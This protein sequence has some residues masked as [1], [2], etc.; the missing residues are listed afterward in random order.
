MY[1]IRM[2]FFSSRERQGA[3]A[4]PINRCYPN[5]HSILVPAV[6]HKNIVVRKTSL[7]VCEQSRWVEFARDM[8]VFPYRGRFA[9]T[10]DML[11]RK[12]RVTHRPLQ[13]PRCYPYRKRGP[14]KNINCTRKKQIHIGIRCTIAS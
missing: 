4:K 9:N 6:V 11:H 7:C 2:R 13:L 10:K 5:I 12:N 1:M 8:Q 3:P 14:W